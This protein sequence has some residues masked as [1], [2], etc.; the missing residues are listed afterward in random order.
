VDT[1]APAPRPPGGWTGLHSLGLAA[2]LAG[3][4][5]V[6]WIVEASRM[7]A[8]TTT[9]AILLALTLLIGQSMTGTWRGALIDPRNRLS[10]S[11]LQMLV[12]TILVISAAYVAMVAN[13]VNEADEPLNVVVPQTLWLLMGLSTTSLAATPLIRSTKEARPPDPEQRERTLELLDAR[14][15]PAEKVDTVGQIVVNVRPKDARWSDVFTGEE[16]GNATYMDLGKAQLFYVTAILALA[17]AEAIAQLFRSPAPRIA[18]L[19]ALDSGLVAL[20]GIS[21][22]GYLTSKAFPQSRQAT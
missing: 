22:I 14:R 17:Y 1:N 12:W 3:L 8:W 11:R 15:G 20:L 9:M 2:G 21:H 10:L 4:V 18:A 19:P 7:T 13:V 5:G 16:V 6:L